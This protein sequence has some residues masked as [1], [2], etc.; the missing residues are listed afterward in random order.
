MLW[1]QIYERW[2]MPDQPGLRQFLLAIIAWL[3]PLMCLHSSEGTDP[4]V[5]ILSI[6]I[7]CGLGLAWTLTTGWRWLRQAP[8]STLVVLLACFAAASNL[9]LM[10]RWDAL[11]CARRAQSALAFYLQ[12]GPGVDHAGPP[13]Y[14]TGIGE[15]RSQVVSDAQGRVLGAYTRDPIMRWSP[16]GFRPGCYVLVRS[17]GTAMLLRDAAALEGALA[18]LRSA[19][20]RDAGAAAP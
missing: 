15:G 10:P 6:G 7:G 1:R 5:L 8:M 2:L 18:Q 9:E 14:A 3:L 11:L 4:R 13:P 19:P 12:A 20:G 16:M 17:D